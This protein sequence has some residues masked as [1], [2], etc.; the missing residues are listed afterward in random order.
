[1]PFCIAVGFVTGDAGIAAFTAA[2]VADARIRALAGKIR[3]V[4]DPKN[5]YPA[6]YTGHVRATLRDGSIVEER[7]ADLRGGAKQPLSRTEI[8]AK[9]M[10]NAAHGGWP[11][12][13]AEAARD[14]A[15]RLF[16]GPIDLSPL[17]G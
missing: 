17:R 10:A 16:D 5:P 14:L 8:E 13:R 7:Q 11:H 2:T 15:R 9:F 3:Y 6:R 4:V 12:A 1:V